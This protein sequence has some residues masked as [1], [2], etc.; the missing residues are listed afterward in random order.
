VAGVTL[1]RPARADEKL[2]L[3]S[4]EGARGGRVRRSE[5]KHAPRW[6]ALR[7]GALALASGLAIAAD[8]DDGDGEDAAALDEARIFI[9]FNASDDDLGFHVFLDGEEWR[10]LR[11]EDPTGRTIFAV[12][13]RGAFARLGLTE[14]FF[15]GAEPSLDEFPS[16]ELLALFPEGEYEVEGET[17]GGDD[18]EG[19]AMLSHA[20]PGPPDPFVQIGA[21]GSLVIRWDPV[22]GP[23]EGFPERPIE[24]VAYQVLVGSFQVGLPAS[25]TSV[26]LPP[27]F[28]ASLG[29]G[30]HE[31][32][33]LAIE[34]GGNRT[35]AQ[36]SFEIPREG[37]APG[38]QSP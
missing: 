7:V 2:G 8:R 17:V 16:D 11:I 19:R 1:R 22:T 3:T 35:I 32:E 31:F 36:G 23:A 33:L 18:L 21:D 29:A 27:E 28:V 5:G 6:P 9:E 15:E 37:P 24:I 34:S 12:S 30:D 13:G 38:A 10:R 25:A 26:T 14:L 20:I 4:L